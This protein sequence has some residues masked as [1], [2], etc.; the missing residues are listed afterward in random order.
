[1]NCHQCYA[2][3]RPPQKMIDVDTTPPVTTPL[4]KTCTHCVQPM[5]PDGTDSVR[6]KLPG[7]NSVQL[8][9]NCVDAFRRTL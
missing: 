7:L 8:H 6:L 2:A 5:K 9:F 3:D 4:G 1:M